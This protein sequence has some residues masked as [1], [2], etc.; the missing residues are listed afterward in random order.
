MIARQ[1]HA[2]MVCPFARSHRGG[3]P[4]K[5]AHTSAC[6]REGVAD[7]TVHGWHHHWASH[8]LMAGI[9]LI[10]IMRMGGWKS[11]RSVQRYAAVD[12]THMH[13]AIGK[14]R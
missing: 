3:N 9:D 12:T 5:R 7:F 1:A 13:K 2:S 10:T 11:I 8:C 14:L 4:A 6:T